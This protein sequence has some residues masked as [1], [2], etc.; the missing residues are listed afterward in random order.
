MKIEELI[1]FDEI[2]EKLE[3]KHNVFQNEVGEVL[4]NQPCF[5]FV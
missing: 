2:I 3:R 4:A 5:R 1:W